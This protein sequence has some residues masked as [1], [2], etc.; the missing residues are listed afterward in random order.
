MYFVE[1]FVLKWN[2]HLSLVN[3]FMVQSNQ[4]ILLQG[5]SNA[6]N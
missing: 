6:I 3:K 1:Y 4:S 5:N 2:R